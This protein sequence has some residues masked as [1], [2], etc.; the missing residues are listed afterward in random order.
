MKTFTVTAIGLAL[1]AAIGTAAANPLDHRHDGYNNGYNGYTTQTRVHGSNH[2][3][4]DNDNAELLVSA[5]LGYAIGAS[6]NGHHHGYGQSGY[7]GHQRYY[8][9]RVYQG[10][11]YGYG[12]QH[13]AYTGWGRSDYYG[14]SGYYGRDDRGSR[15][16]RDYRDTR[17]QRYQDADYDRERIRDDSDRDDYQY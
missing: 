9:G 2:Y 4:H 17:G 8:N 6:A 11:G 10:S 1:S 16:D 15:Y 12:Y 13:N 14:N 3:R 5:L 7:Y